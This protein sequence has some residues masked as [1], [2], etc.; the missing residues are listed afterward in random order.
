MPKSRY[1]Y[2]FISLTL[3]FYN[4]SV[5]PPYLRTKLG[6]ETPISSKKADLHRLW[7]RPAPTLV[8]WYDGVVVEEW[9][10]SGRAIME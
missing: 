5:P 1:I 8:R 9:G 7:Y 3:I 2:S 6:E 10:R 4:Y